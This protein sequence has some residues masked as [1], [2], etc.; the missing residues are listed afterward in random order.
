[1][2]TN[3][4]TVLADRLNRDVSVEWGAGVD[5]NSRWR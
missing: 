5:R 4:N 2:S 3:C 1:L